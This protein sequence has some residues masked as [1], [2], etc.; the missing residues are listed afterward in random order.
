MQACVYVCVCVRISVCRAP[1]CTHRR[2]CLCVHVPV[3]IHTCLYTCLRTPVFVYV[4]CVHACPRPCVCTWVCVCMCACVCVPTRVC[5]GAL[6]P[7]VQQFSIR[8]LL[9]QSEEFQPSQGPGLGSPGKRVLSGR[10]GNVS[11]YGSGSRCCRPA[12]PYRYILA[13]LTAGTEH[14]HEHARR[15]AS[16][17]MQ[18]GRCSPVVALLVPDSSRW[19]GC[20]KLPRLPQRLAPLPPRLPPAPPPLPCCLIDTRPG[21]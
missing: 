8:L 11:F 9:T 7:V 5:L 19:G 16:A 21:L 1:V 18:W 10:D 2:V 14:A 4:H 17:K 20:W 12:H 13:T 6:L 15:W 3:C